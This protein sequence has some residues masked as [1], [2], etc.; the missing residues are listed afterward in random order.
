MGETA[1]IAQIPKTSPKINVR[2]PAAFKV[3]LLPGSIYW[4]FQNLRGQSWSR[5]VLVYLT[6]PLSRRIPCGRGRC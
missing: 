3:I 2:M 6:N 4:A 5:G 1:L